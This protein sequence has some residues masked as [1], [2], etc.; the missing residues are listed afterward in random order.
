MFGYRRHLVLSTLVMVW[1]AVPALAETPFPSDG[2][3]G[4]VLFWKNVFTEYGA[5]DIIIHDRFHVNLIYAVARDETVEARVRAVKEALTEIRGKV[6]A[7]EELSDAA[8][9]IYQA[10]V[11]QRLAPSR[12]RS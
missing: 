4:R 9:A 2:L 12:R 11:D 7:P 8:S 1:L 10:I 3:E 5:D 6:E